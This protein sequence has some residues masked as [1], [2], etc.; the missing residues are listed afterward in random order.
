MELKQY[1]VKINTN[2][3]LVYYVSEYDMEKA[4]DL[5]L[6]APYK[7]WEVSEFTEPTYNSIIVDEGRSY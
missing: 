6:D 7:E 1:T 5:A 3:T 4:I 2:A